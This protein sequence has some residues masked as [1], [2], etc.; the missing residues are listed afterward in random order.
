MEAASSS[1]RHNIIELVFN[2]LLLLMIVL[3]SV[4][5]AIGQQGT[6]TIL[7]YDTNLQTI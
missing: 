7:M 2:A 5:V 4:Q 1:N 6:S 3:F